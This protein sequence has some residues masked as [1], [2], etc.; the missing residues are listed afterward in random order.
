[1]YAIDG[2]KEILSA[3]VEET[4]SSYIDEIRKMLPNGPFLFLGFSSGG[5][6]A[7]EMARQ[8]HAMNCEVLF[9]GMLDTFC[10]IDFKKKTSL[11]DTAAIAR[12]LKNFP[13]WLYYYVPFWLNHYMKKTKDESLFEEPPIH[14]VIKRLH[15]YTPHYYK[16][17]IVFYRSRAQ[18]IIP[19]TA[20]ES[21]RTL[22]EQVEV[23][24]V[25]GHHTGILKG[26]AVR[27]LA[28]KINA[29]LYRSVKK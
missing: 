14:E 25:P 7:F 12:S 13:F 23:H 1:V 20:H 6:I 29:E 27:A 9:L 8:L 24:I 19:A 16:G 11:S 28:K 3:S 5:V 15:D 17:R 4:A 21:W 10:P 18:G 22:A 26:S 2:S